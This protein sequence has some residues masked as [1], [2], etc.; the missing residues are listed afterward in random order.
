M[1]SLRHLYRLRIRSR[2]IVKKTSLLHCTLFIVIHDTTSC[3]DKCGLHYYKKARNKRQADITAVQAEF[4]A[5]QA[6]VTGRVHQ[7][8]PRSLRPR[9]RKAEITG[10]VPVGSK[11]RRLADVNRY[12]KILS[13]IGRYLVLSWV[14]FILLIT[15]I[16][17]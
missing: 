5:A 4:T 9:S 14:S 8:W 3:I 15:Y 17:Q 6:D 7:N 12:L 2:P 1:T 16:Q 10:N 13:G 11:R